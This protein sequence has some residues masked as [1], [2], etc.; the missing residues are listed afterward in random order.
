MLRS[1]AQ[2]SSIIIFHET[3]AVDDENLSNPYSPEGGFGESGGIVPI[4]PKGAGVR[5]RMANRKPEEWH[6][7]GRV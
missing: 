4:L 5:R 3:L 7:M 1:A 6:F 2:L